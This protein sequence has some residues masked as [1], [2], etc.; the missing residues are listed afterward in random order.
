MPGPVIQKPSW[1]PA[2]IASNLPRPLQWAGGAALQGLKDLSGGDDPN[3][4]MGAGV[5]PMTVPGASS[6]APALSSLMNIHPDL[7]EAGAGV[8]QH[9]PSGSDVDALTGMLKHNLAKVP[10]AGQKSSTGALKGLGAASQEYTPVGAEDA[11]NSTRSG[12]NPATRPPPTNGTDQMAWWNALTPAQKLL[13][14]G[15]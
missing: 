15:R 4:M 6:V 14:G 12:F 8:A 5:M 1:D 2:A 11:F 9:M 13:Q 3:A 7:V 10:S